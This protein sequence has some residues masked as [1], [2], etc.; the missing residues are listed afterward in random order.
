MDHDNTVVIEIDGN[1]LPES[2]ENDQK[3]FGDGEKEP[4]AL[5]PEEQ[6]ARLLDG[7]R[8]EAEQILLDA[9]AASV[10]EQAA[11][12]NAV[13]SEIAVMK[14]QAKEEGYNEGITM[15]TRE[16]DD[17]RAQARKVL[18][19]AEAE[20]KTMQQKLEPEMV[21]LL[22]HIVTKLIDNAVSLNPDIIVTLVRLGMQN[23]TI[24]G[25][26]A[27]YV[28]PAD[29]DAAIENKDRIM[30]LTDGSVKLNI[31]KDLS[32]NAMDCIIETP[33]GNIDCSLGQQLESLCHN[34]TYLLNG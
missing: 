20:R 15:A 6:A 19:D 22:I 32:L 1:L 13:K 23:A 27:V 8:K 25:D 24:T 33:F 3:G 9:Q 26:V 29:Y 30:A 5:S 17:I 12:R 18:A 28:S 11:M 31:I 14:E 7:A 16:G 10:A 2:I 34:I 4:P 21:D